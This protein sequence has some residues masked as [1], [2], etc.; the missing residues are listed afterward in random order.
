[1]TQPSIRTSRRSSRIASSQCHCQ[2]NQREI[3]RTGATT[4]ARTARTSRVR[5]L[6]LLDL[7]PSDRIYQPSYRVRDERL[8]KAGEGGVRRPR[9][10]PALVQE[11]FRVVERGERTVGC[12]PALVGP[13]R[14]EL[15]HTRRVRGHAT[16]AIVTIGNEIVSGDIENTNASWL[17]RRLEQLG[18]VVQ[19]VTAVPDDVDAIARLVRREAEEADVVVVTGGLGGTPDDVTREAIAAVFGVPQREHEEVAA[20]LRARFTRAPDYAASWAQLPDGARPLEIEGGGAPG[21]VL[22]NVYVLPGLPGEMKPM[23]E[24]LEEELRRERPISSWRR[25]FATRESEITPLL[26]EVSR[27]YPGVR[28]GSYPT[29]TP[30][31]PLVEVVVKSADEDTLTG[32]AQWLA[33]EIEALTTS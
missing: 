21:F 24:A 23:F 25:T 2:E 19:L 9:E 32:A 14:E 15:L 17:A 28:V 16:A 27:R 22:E 4:A 31:G 33:A 6:H 11:L 26:V 30:E 8:E 1:M 29:F 13:A 20:R 5:A 12:E 7:G 18:I 3:S 10:Q